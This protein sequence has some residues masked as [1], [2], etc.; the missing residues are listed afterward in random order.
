[1]IA[2]WSYRLALFF[3]LAAPIAI[4]LFYLPFT[5]DFYQFNKLVLYYVLTGLGLLS[6]LIY[7]IAGK[8]VRLT[9]ST[10]LLPFFVLALVTV[11]SIWFNPPRTA[12]I[13]LVGG[14]IYLVSFVYF[15]LISTIIQTAPQVKTGLLLITSSLGVTALAAAL[16]FNQTGSALSLVSLLI[17]WLPAAL[18]L[19]FKARSGPKKIAYFLL[20]GIMVSSLILNGYKL[21]PGRELQPVLLN[22]LAAWSIGVDT[23]KTKL[24]FGTGPGRFSE[25]FTRFKPISLNLTDFWN[26]NFT[27]SANVYLELLTT[28]GLTGL[29]AW[30]WLIGSVN[31]LRRRLP[32]TRITSSQLALLTSF[33]IQILL[34]LAIPFTTVNWV[35]FVITVSLL[36][37]SQKSKQTPQVKDVLLTLSAVSLVE[38]GDAGPEPKQGAALLP[39]V[40][41][42]PATLG[43]IIVFFNLTKVYAADYYFKQSLD[44]ANKNQGKATYDLQV[45]TLA[46]A[47]SNDRY[48]V[49]YANTNLALANSLAAKTDLSDQERQV[50]AT[51]IQQAIREARIATQIA[52][53]KAAAWANLANIYKNLVNFA[54]GAGDFSQAAYV[55]A[56]QLDPANPGLRLDLGGLF[57]GLKNYDLARDRFLETIQLK[58]NLANAYYNLSFV[59]QQQEKW[60]EAYQAMQQVA[61]LVEP[62]TDDGT[63][64]RNELAELEKK[65]PPAKTTQQNETTTGQLAAPSPAP[66]APKNLPEIEL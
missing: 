34:A 7:S 26:V 17:A 24:F 12:E 35:L 25:S 31:R 63:K 40:L 16:N 39:W 37:A 55:R 42:L 9:L 41:A 18:I 30:L 5:T 53:N 6:W 50:V 52:P 48:R 45:K 46:L 15:L 62:D 58:P 11:A 21:L 29:L 14:G 33:F 28:L 49:A 66:N 56:I 19:A 4:P 10:P 38:P 57:Y 47:P 60:L 65:L 51:L 54:D 61:A 20:S 23:L 8:T 1:M 22:P 3:L 44:A 27:V 13:W 2:K 64:V 36:V 32:G 59:Y 43:L